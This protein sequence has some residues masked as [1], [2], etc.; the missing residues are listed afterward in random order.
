MTQ[1]IA[2]FIVAGE[3]PAVIAGFKNNR[4]K[5]LTLLESGAFDLESGKIE[6]NVN[7]GQIQSIHTYSMKY[8]RK[9]I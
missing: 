5:F 9:K 4:E 6:I 8:K 3:D 7:N 1:N 2:K